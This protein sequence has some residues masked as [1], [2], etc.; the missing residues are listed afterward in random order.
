MYVLVLYSLSAMQKGIQSL[1]SVVE[2]GLKYNKTLEYNEWAKK[3]KTVIILDGGTTS[4]KWL[5]TKDGKLIKSVPVGT[6]QKHVMSL[7]DNRIKT[8]IF[9]EPDCNDS[10]TA[11]CFLVNERGFSKDYY[12]PDTPPPFPQLLGGWPGNSGV[13][14]KPDIGK[15]NEFLQEFL[16]QFRL[17]S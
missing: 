7:K 5:N 1:H 14:V 13:Q 6:L 4:D 8:A 16:R 2:Y 3:S 11:I 10:L 9:R 15:D 17:A 12:T